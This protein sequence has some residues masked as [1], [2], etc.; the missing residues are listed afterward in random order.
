[1]TCKSSSSPYENS[2]KSKL[3]LNVFFSSPISHSPA[4]KLLAWVGLK[5]SL[6]NVV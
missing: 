5:R 6:F 2:A 1:M 4:H 3:P